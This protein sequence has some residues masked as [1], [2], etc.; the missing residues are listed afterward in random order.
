MFYLDKSFFIDAR[1]PVSQLGSAVTA[2][3]KK[4]YSKAELSEVYTEEELNNIFGYNSGIAI[5]S[6]SFTDADGNIIYDIEGRD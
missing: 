6:I 2:D 5:E 3:M 4:A 1:L